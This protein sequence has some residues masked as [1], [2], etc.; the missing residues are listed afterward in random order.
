MTK[1]MHPSHRIDVLSDALSYYR[2]KSAR[3][4]CKFHIHSLWSHSACY[5]DFLKGK[6]LPKRLLRA[7]KVGQE[8]THQLQELMDNSPGTALKFNLHIHVLDR[9]ILEHLIYRVYMWTRCCSMGWRGENRV[10]SFPKIRN[11]LHQLTIWYW[12]WFCYLCEHRGRENAKFS[13]GAMVSSQTQKQVCWYIKH[14]MASCMCIHVI[15]TTC[16]IL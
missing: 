10:R 8:S 3:N 6:L 11:R 7:R 16:I 1:E 9:I 5:S 2:L 14:C 15:V 4:L 12:C 13:K